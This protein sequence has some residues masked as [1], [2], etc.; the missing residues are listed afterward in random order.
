VSGLADSAMLRRDRL[1]PAVVASVAVHLVLGLLALAGHGPAIDLGQQPITARLVRLGEPRPRELLPRKEEPPSAETG[2]EA[3]PPEPVVAPPAPAAP[4]AKPG[5]AAKAV[6]A[7]K[8]APKPH[9]DKT[10]AAS[11]ARRLG[12]VLAG[13]KQELAAGSPDGDP[14]GDSNEAVGDQYQAQVV[15][16]LKQNYRLPSTLSEKERLYLQGTIVLFIESDGR[17][18]RHEFLKRSGNSTFDEALERAVRDTRLP[19]PPAEAREG[20]R[21]RGLQVDFKI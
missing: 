13:M 10:A 16:S 8:A 14:L 3:A 12:N 5:P 6:V 2:P 11:G 17:V 19:P 4:A 15:R 9:P 20:Y 18:L 21:R 7:T 1:W